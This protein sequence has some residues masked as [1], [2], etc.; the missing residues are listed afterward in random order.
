M[1]LSI[2][3][4]LKWHYFVYSVQFTNINLCTVTAVHALPKGRYTLVTLPR[5][6]TPYRDSVDG[7]C[8]HVTYQKLVTRLRYGRVRCAVGIWP[9]HQRDGTVTAWAGVDGQR[10]TSPPPAASCRH[11]SGSRNKL[12]TPMCDALRI[13]LRREARDESSAR[14]SV[15][16]QSLSTLRRYGTR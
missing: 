14:N 15:S 7:T 10:D 11:R 5:N 16:C 3:W 8:D 9:S 1:W 6:V 4:L 2:I 13:L 12:R